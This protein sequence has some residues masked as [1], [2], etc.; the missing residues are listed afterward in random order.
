MADIIFGKVNPSGKLPISFPR[1]VGHI[2]S[3]YNHKPTGRGCYHK[4][5][6]PGKPG[7]DYVF[8][9]TTPLFD[10]GHGLSYARFKYSNL[11]VTPTKVTPKGQVEVRVDV[12]NT[13]HLAG[14]EIVQLYIND[15][16]SSTTTPVKALKG[17]RKISLDPNQKQSVRFT[18][19]SDDLS[20]LDE[21][22][23][24]V[25]EAGKFEVM[26]GGLKKRFEVV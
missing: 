3:Y 11:R 10:F 17:F 19:T 20:L 23:Q 2:Q 12:A 7:R 13:G 9:K 6:Q 16:V 4:S 24:R 5:G 14:K 26:V 1:S 8:S 15:M 22:M 21:N 25:V 18:L